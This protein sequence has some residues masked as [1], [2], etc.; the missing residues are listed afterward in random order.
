MFSPYTEDDPGSQH[1]VVRPTVCSTHC[2]C[3]T[4]SHLIS[5]SGD[6]EVY[7]MPMSRAGMR[8]SGLACILLFEHGCCCLP[9]ETYGRNGATPIFRSFS[10]NCQFHH[11]RLESL[12]HLMCL[13]YILLSTTVSHFLDLTFF[14]QGLLFLYTFPFCKYTLHVCYVFNVNLTDSFDDRRSQ[15]R[16]ID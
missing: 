12:E 13:I 4:N 2:S 5:A 3:A 7:H 10:Q 6:E 8:P 15:C 16:L 1:L 14:L 9:S 11:R